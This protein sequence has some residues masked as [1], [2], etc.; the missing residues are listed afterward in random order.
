MIRRS[1]LVFLL[2]TLAWLVAGVQFYGRSYA[3]DLAAAL[4]WWGLLV[5]F[6]AAGYYLIQVAPAAR[7]TAWL[8]RDLAINA[9]LFLVLL[10]TILD[11]INGH[12]WLSLRGA[13]WVAFGA[14]LLHPILVD[15]PHHRHHRG[16]PG[17]SPV[18]QYV[19]PG[20]LWIDWTLAVLV[21]GGLLLL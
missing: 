15:R 12:R 6:L 18:P 19:P 20:C 1:Y 9:V 4:V 11:G 17:G 13:G 3:F 7:V 2:L 10:G 8:R 14:A 5:M 21:L 16:D